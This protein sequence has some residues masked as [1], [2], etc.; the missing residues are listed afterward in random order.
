[1]MMGA[2][3]VHIGSNTNNISV[4][5]VMVIVNFRENLVFDLGM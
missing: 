2:H 1:M 5:L 4:V 3:G